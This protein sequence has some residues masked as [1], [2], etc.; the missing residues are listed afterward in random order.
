MNL[1]S[2][3]GNTA[4]DRKQKSKMKLLKNYKSISKVKI[5]YYLLYFSN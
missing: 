3:Q 4:V 1:A 2:D 5:S